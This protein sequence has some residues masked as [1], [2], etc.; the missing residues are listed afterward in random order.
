[1]SHTDGDKKQLQ[2]MTM[3]YILLM[4]AGF[5]VVGGFIKIQLVERKMWM[6]IAEKHEAEEIKDEARR[7]NI[8]SSDGKIMATTI[9]ICNLYVDMGSRLV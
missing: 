5:F 1:M 3:V 9:P 4:V 6:D 7:G 8:Y 2:R